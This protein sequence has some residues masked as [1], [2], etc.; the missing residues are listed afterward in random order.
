MMLLVLSKIM[1]TCVAT[2]LFMMAIAAVYKDS[3]KKEPADWFKVI[4]GLVVV[5]G[6][7]C[8][9]LAVFI[10]IWSIPS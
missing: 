1:L 4:G 2:V 7:V 3:A 8:L 6:F 5:T 10:A 9:V